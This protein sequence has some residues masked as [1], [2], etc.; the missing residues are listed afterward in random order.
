M[1]PKEQNIWHAKRLIALA[2]KSAVHTSRRIRAG[3]PARV[4]LLRTDRLMRLSN[5]A[6]QQ[7]IA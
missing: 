6:W 1:S 7:A 5:I 4:A 2:A 3:L